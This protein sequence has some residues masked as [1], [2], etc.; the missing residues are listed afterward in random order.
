[1][2]AFR[3]SRRAVIGALGLAGLAA[4]SRDAAKPAAEPALA[5]PAPTPGSLEWAA[6]GAWRIDADR[7]RWRHPVETLKFLGIR[8]NMTVLEVL[9]GQGWYSAVLAPYLAR[10]GGKLFAATFNPEGASPAQLETL[11]AYRDKFLADA[12]TYGKVEMTVLEPKGGR[13]AP[14]DSCDL[15]LIMRT[16][17]TLMAQG[18]A[19]QVL[20]DVYRAL[21]PGGLLGVE[22]HRG[23]A[24]GLQD[25]QAASGYVQEAFVKQ[26]ASEAGFE[27]VGASQINANP[28]DDREHPFGVWTLPPVLRTAP[29]GSVPDPSFDTSPYQ[30]IGESDRMTLK[31]RK[32]LTAPAP[33]KPGAG[34]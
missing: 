17:H 9:P 27:F 13:V 23:K 19:E 25:P 24:T 18:A 33:L 5:L 26:I 32:P 14:D 12:A 2:V 30:A 6:A 21:K 10:G 22:Q 8:S 15:A 3:F 34:R 1:M 16:L 20:R 29:L 4:C 28:K 31:F 7:D 11:K